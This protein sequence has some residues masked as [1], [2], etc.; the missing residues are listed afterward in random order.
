MRVL[1]SA[2]FS[3]GHAYPALALARALS[4]RGHQVLVELSERWRE[5]VAELG[6]AFTAANDYTSFPGAG[7]SRQTPTVFDATRALA[8]VL[9]EFEPDVVVADLVA[10]APDLAAEIAGVPAA[11]LIPTVFPVQGSGLPPFLLG[12]QAPRTRLGGH[13]WRV[14]EPATRALRPSARWV[15]RVP[16]LL[17]EVRS[18][19]GLPPL[20]ADPQRT[21]TYGTISGGLALVATFPQLEYPRRWPAGV[22]VTGPMRFELA[23]PPVSVPA[24]DEPLVVVASSTVQD[25]GHELVRASL[26]GLAREPVR[27]LASLNRRGE[28]WSEP[29]PANAAVVDWASYAEVMARASLVVTNGGHGTVVRALAA[30]LPPLVCP[31]GADAAENGA[32]VAWA[33]VGRMLPRRLLAPSSLRWAVRRLLADHG[34]TER[35][36]AIA[37]WDQAHDGAVRGA[38]LLEAYVRS[39]TGAFPSEPR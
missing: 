28:T 33:G 8:A 9:A 32:R 3:E 7:G 36:R 5:Q 25:P 27:V 10:P 2:G 20:A 12:L 24:G 30:G 17:D 38:E 31:T 34:C 22:E 29:V 21:T 1:I 13:A 35:A 39:A 37:A 14:I 4:D 11:T 18:E 16:G 23:H 15:A 6:L 19:L 26:R